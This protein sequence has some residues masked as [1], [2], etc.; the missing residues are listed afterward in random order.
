MGCD[1]DNDDAFFLVCLAVISPLFFSFFRNN[2]DGS[3]VLSCLSLFPREGGEG[4]R[5]LRYVY[6]QSSPGKGGRASEPLVALYVVWGVSR[7]L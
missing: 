4:R 2:F 6:S 1:D 3:A 7:A 5:R